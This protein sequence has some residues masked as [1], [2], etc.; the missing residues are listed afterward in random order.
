MAVPRVLPA[1][2]G[3]VAIVATT[4]IVVVHCVLAHAL[5][6]TSSPVRST[7]I[8]SAFFE[9]VV[10]ALEIWLLAT[11]LRPFAST[12]RRSRLGKFDGIWFGLS[13]LLC[14]VAATCSV[15]ALVCLSNANSGLPATILGS[16]R[17]GF[18]VGGSVALGL[19]FATQL[20]FIVV[21]YVLERIPQHDQAH[22]V[23][24][25]DEA[26]RP[27]A[28]HVKSIPY[29]QTS[30]PRA[31]KTRNRG[32]SLESRS[33]PSSSGGRSATETISSIRSSLSHAVRP[34]SSK[35]RLL[36][37]SQR[38]ARRAASVDSNSQRERSSV[39]DGFD[40]WDTSSVD[41]NNRQTVLE[42]TSPIPARFLETIPASPTTSRS[43]SPGTPLDLEPPRHRRRSRS[44]S[45]ANSLRGPRPTYT[46]Q[47]SSSE[48][49]IHPLFRSDSPTPPPLATPGTM[50]VAAPN[51][52][53]IIP[54]RQSV[55]TLSR[56]RSGSLPA[57]SSP[58]SRH[59][60]FDDFHHPSP[61]PPGTPGS[62]RCTPRERG[63]SATVGSPDDTDDTDEELGTSNSSQLGSIAEPGERKMTPP[64]PEWILSAGS[65]T[66][67]SG[68]NSRKLRIA[69]GGATSPRKSDE[70]GD[71]VGPSGST[72]TLTPARI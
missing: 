63:R 58:L 11:N 47:Q 29:S 28:V 45:P 54:D 21:R 6:S 16:K 52:G 33:P 61:K 49:H 41:P 9:I 25:D 57:V 13:L 53:Q 20:V 43:P 38:S 72:V 8:A 51:A 37:N 7:A 44:Y 62:G 64:I 26:R 67:L 65:R 32:F 1:V 22:S 31:A 56:M 17:T 18:L 15:A 71:D 59:G 36:S 12:G 35:T 50:V 3:S 4:A 24:T 48:A 68:Y 39:E 27:Q 42:T 66:S 34:I 2:L 70:D 30:S 69:V 55:R 23:H 40:S 46:Q 19:S 14:V 60:S 10:L 5:L